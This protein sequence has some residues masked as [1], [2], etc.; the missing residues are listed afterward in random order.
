M[1][2]RQGATPAARAA[3][4]ASAVLPFTWRIDRHNEPATP[5]A[6]PAPEPPPANPAAP[7]PAAGD[8]PPLG[9]AGEKALNEFKERARKAEADLTAAR[10]RITE[11]ED[12]D[13]TDLERAQSAA[14]AAE[15]RAADAEAALLRQRVIN[16]T[17][18]KPELAKFLPT[19]DEAALRAAAAEL[20]AAT[21]VPAA[22]PGPRPD[23][24]QGS[25]RP[26]V[27]TDFR[28]ASHE[29][30]KAEMARLGVRTAR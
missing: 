18:L 7:E 9:P 1:N 27:P 12:R 29:E 24:S 6:P 5:A 14:A 3:A 26:V 19:G 20:A 2:R 16:E 28:T 13:K 21:T 11:F 23:P 8:D 30:F 22:P 4:T 15:Q 25:G 10:Q 17:G